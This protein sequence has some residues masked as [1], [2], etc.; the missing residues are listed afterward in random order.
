[1]KKE[2]Y[3]EFDPRTFNDSLLFIIN[4]LCQTEDKN[5]NKVLIGDVEMG[6]VKNNVNL[7]FIKYYTVSKDFK[8]P[9]F[10]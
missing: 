9:T 3:L 10:L 4:H 2:N 1:M 5:N 8:E 6:R 7:H